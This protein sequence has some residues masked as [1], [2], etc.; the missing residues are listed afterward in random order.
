MGN[1]RKNWATFLFL[2]L[3][4]L[5]VDLLVVQDDVWPPDVIRRHVK[6][7]D[8]TI[9][10]G[11]PLQLVVVPVLRRERRMLGIRQQFDQ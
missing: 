6:H 3:V 10:L 7:V 2:H 1:F 4:T 11:V 5:V 9:L 8:A